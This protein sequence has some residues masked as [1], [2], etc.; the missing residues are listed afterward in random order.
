MLPV[1]WNGS[2]TIYK[3]LIRPFVLRHQKEIDTAIDEAVGATR[4]ALKEG[5][6]V[7]AVFF[8]SIL[9]YLLMVQNRIVRFS[10]TTTRAYTHFNTKYVTDIR[11]R[12]QSGRPTV[13]C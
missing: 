3:R 4:S 11:L 7:I 10:I 9:Q 1:S 12:P 6:F 8:L 2:D 13:P 5:Q